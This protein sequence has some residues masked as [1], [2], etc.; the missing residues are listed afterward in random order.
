MHD[1]LIPGWILAAA[2]GWVVAFPVLAVTMPPVP[3]P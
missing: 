2:I 1:T 3:T